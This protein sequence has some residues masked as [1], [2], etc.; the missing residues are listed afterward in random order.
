[1]KSRIRRLL[2][3]FVLL[4]FSACA[5]CTGTTGAS[6]EQFGEIPETEKMPL[7]TVQLVSGTADTRYK[8]TLTAS[9]DTWSVTIA[10]SRRGAIISAGTFGEMQLLTSE[11][12]RMEIENHDGTTSTLFS[13]NG[14][15]SVDLTQDGQS[16]RL[17]FINPENIEGLAVEVIGE[18]GPDGISWCTN[19]KNDTKDYSVSS[20]SYPTPGVASDTLHLFSPER[21]GRA[22]MDAGKNGFNASYEYPGHI[23]SMQYFAFWGEEGGIYLGI[24]DP[25]GGMK[26]FTVD[27][28]YGEGRLS[29]VYPAIGASTVGNSFSVGGCIRWEA[30][31][32]DW[33]DAT[34]LYA[35]FVHHNAKW[36]PTYGRPDTA[37]Q[38]KE[39][40][41]WMTDFNEETNLNGTLK[42]REYIGAPIATHAYS[43]YC[44]TESVQPLRSDQNRYRQLEAQL[45]YRAPV[46]P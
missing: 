18:A 33:Y 16:I 46:F 14:W 43:L 12:F 31:S 42:I 27:V 24:H 28:S 38:F 1:M 40:A 5:G 30:F 34:M 7:R 39:I 19:V 35:D 3:L 11:L 10:S 36:L 44:D 22:V 9:S 21:S 8:E 2:S 15:E 41:M 17:N 32:G 29:A 26:S 13:S 45:P 23:L 6:S 20:I 4:S 37:E 25:D